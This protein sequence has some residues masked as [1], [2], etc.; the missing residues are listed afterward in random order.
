MHRIDGAGHVAGMFTEGV[1]GVTPATQ[2]TDDWLN[3]VQEEIANV[4]ETHEFLAKGDN[5]QLLNAIKT[6]VPRSWRVD[7]KP[8]VVT[9]LAD[10][11][12][13]SY[14]NLGKVFHMNGEI[15]YSN[16]LDNA[17]SLLFTMIVSVTGEP[18]MYPFYTCASD[19]E[20]YLYVDGVLKHTYTTNTGYNLQ[21]DSVE[22]TEGNHIIQV[23][24]NNSGG[25]KSDLMLQP[26]MIGPSI[27]FVRSELA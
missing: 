21:G 24:H 4:V 14:V 8:S 16:H 10:F 18:A 3:A 17:H 5:T 11:I 20:T 23:L 12:A 1:P 9:T 26:F 2:I 15:I 22:L 19:D 7:I 27:Y 13:G 6:M 25:T